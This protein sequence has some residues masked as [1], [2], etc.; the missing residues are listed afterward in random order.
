MK[1]NLQ[2]M[3]L[4]VL[5]Q[6]AHSAGAYYCF[7][8]TQDLIPGYIV[9]T[10]EGQTVNV[11][12][13]AGLPVD[14]RLTDY[15]AYWGRRLPDAERE[16]YF[17][18]FDRET[19]LKRYAAGEE[20]L[21]L[22]YW[23][24]TA[25]QKPMLAEQHI[26][27]FEEKSTGEIQG[28]TYILD[29]TEREREQ[30]RRRELEQELKKSL[31]E[32]DAH[33]QY[34]ELL[35]HDFLVVYLVNLREDTS[36]PIKADPCVTK[37]DPVKVNLRKVNPYRE[38]IETYSR[39]FVAPDLQAEFARVMAAENLLRVLEDAP[40]FVYRYRTTPRREGQQ[41]F[42]AQALRMQETAESGRVLIGFRCIDDV[43]TAEQRRQIELEEQME[44]E[45]HQLE[46]LQALGRNYQAIFRIDL[47][48]D[49]YLELACREDIRPYYDSSD[50]SAARTLAKLCETAISTR[51]LQ[52]MQ[53]FFDLRTL[54]QRL[55]DREYVE[56]E[57][58]TKDTTWHRAKFIVKRRNE[59]GEA[60]HVLYVTQIIDSEKQYEERLIAKAEYAEYANRAKTE[61]ISQIAH[62]IRT[63]LNS[64]FGFL[65]IAEADLCNQDKVRYS[66]QRIRTAGEFLNALADDVLDIS[67]MEQGKL[68]LDLKPVS[69][70]RLMKEFEE[71]SR[72]A[73][74]D[75]RHHVCFDVHHILHDRVVADPLRLHQIYN[76]VFTNAVKYTPDGGSI[77]MEVY[78]QSLPDE[79]KVRLVS[80]ITDTGIGMSEGFMEKM[81]AKFERETDTRV[82]QISGFGLG[83]SIVKQLVDLMGGTI[84]VRS[85]QGEGTAF[86]I[87]VDVSYAQEE[88]GE[89]A[90]PQ[91]DH[92]AACAGLHLLVAEDNE[93]NREV[94]TALLE[95]H[96]MTCDCVENGTLCLERLCTS[97]QGCYDAVLMDMQMPVMN[98]VEAAKQIRALPL[99]WAKTIPI[100]AMTA[101][102]MQNDVHSCLTAGMNRHLAKPVDMVRL[103]DALWELAVCGTE[104]IE[105]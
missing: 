77:T 71:F 70:S 67:R 47:E 69:L 75:Q 66:L 62:D 4:R 49:S 100:L 13:Q 99:P 18:F 73:D 79:G 76:N 34:L 9:E 15:L 98:G 20:H 104:Q 55:S 1:A 54:A 63:P 60:T 17:T 10:A 11:N 91:A 72:T 39:G 50:P 30:A 92:T 56:A 44:R 68:K 103:T 2:E 53:Q 41:Y 8:L 84:Q 29:R 78:Q 40:R 27:L 19:M 80:V 32:R 46:I 57:C 31:A 38:R 25:T 5:E 101:N 95:M 45:H 28:I 6:F 93:L 23:T 37:Y 85:R 51:Y 14:A 82:N 3:K 12:R 58:V 89:S 87:S 105:P 33:R 35:T 94:M 88:T 52:R 16:A 64:I 21:S 102:A 61:F 74:I 48:N 36:I 97:P 43:V 86:T 83:L 24:E 26:F 90:Q 59:A 7:N 96:G 81:F 22:T 65:E 42:E